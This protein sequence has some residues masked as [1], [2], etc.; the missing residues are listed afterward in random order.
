MA[1]AYFYMTAQGKKIVDQLSQVYPGEIFD[2]TNYKEGIK[3]FW[4]KDN[5]LIFIMAT[6]IVVRHIAPYIQSKDQDP[7]VVVCDQNGSF[8]ISL[9]SGH[10]GGAN[11][12]AR[13]IAKLLHGQAVITTATDVVNVPAMDEFAKKNHLKI[14]NIHEMKYV[15]G[16]MVEQKPLKILTQWQI[17]GSFPKNVQVFDLSKCDQDEWKKLC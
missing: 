15:S 10:L 6:G 5:A 3:A 16:A 2:K 4:Q 13:K 9:L 1:I 12:L 14:E 8:A 7:A 17:K 11:E